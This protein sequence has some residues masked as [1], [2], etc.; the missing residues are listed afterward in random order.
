[1][2]AAALM[3]AAMMIC[4]TGCG[5]SKKETSEGKGEGARKFEGTT[6]YMIAEQQTPT[7]ALQSQLDDFEELTGM[8]WITSRSPA[9]ARSISR[10]VIISLLTCWQFDWFHHTTPGTIRQ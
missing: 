5:S 3:L 2:R 6:L 9:A 1:M 4:T 7:I 8:L 10:I